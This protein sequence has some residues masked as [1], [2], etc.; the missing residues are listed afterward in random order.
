MYSNNWKCENPH[1]G[2][3]F[4]LQ[5]SNQLSLEIS[6]KSVWRP[7][8]NQPLVLYFNAHS[9]TQ[10]SSTVKVSRHTSIFW[11]DFFHHPAC[12]FSSLPW[13]VCLKA[14]LNV[15]QAKEYHSRHWILSQH[16]GEGRG[17]GYMH[18]ILRSPMAILYNA[19]PTEPPKRQLTVHV[20]RYCII[21]TQRFTGGMLVTHQRGRCWM[22]TYFSWPHICTWYIQFYQL[23][24]LITSWKL[25]DSLLQS[26][27]ETFAWRLLILVLPK[28]KHAGYYDAPLSKRPPK[29][30]EIYTVAICNNKFLVFSCGLPLKAHNMCCKSY[31]PGSWCTHS[32][33]IAIEVRLLR[34][35]SGCGLDGHVESMVSLITSIH[36][37]M[38]SH[39]NGWDWSVLSIVASKLK[40]VHQYLLIIHCLHPC[41]VKQSANMWQH[42]ADSIV[43]TA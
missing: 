38:W 16:M 19:Q 40:W 17:G 7:G 21:G 18:T 34:P 4:S 26:K 42:S 1:L 33:R 39:V 25:A 27:Q 24:L 31:T 14:R 43:L 20:T 37:F 15:G 5:N 9:S 36:A 12:T 10:D 8:K 2:C 6:S 32:K 28:R 29:S 23:L 35:G 30:V 22:S 13:S 11:G 3:T 41:T